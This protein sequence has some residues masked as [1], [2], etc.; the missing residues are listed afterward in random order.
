[1]AAQG[2]SAARSRAPDWS[3]GLPSDHLANIVKRLPSPPAPTRRRSG[4]CARRAVRV[5]LR[6]APA[7]PVRPRRRP[8][9]ALQRRR[10]QA[11][12]PATPPRR[13]TRRRR[14]AVRR[15]ARVG[16]AHGR[17]RVRRAAQPL[18]D[19]PRRAP[20]AR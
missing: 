8:R 4:P 1:M 12:D 9:H 17:V 16:G 6:A 13:V 3:S 2:S 11:A 20:A 18:H 19:R 5:L 10:R 15:V 14:G 7:P